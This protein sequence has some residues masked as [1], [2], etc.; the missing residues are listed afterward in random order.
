ML[1]KSLKLHSPTANLAVRRTNLYPGLH[2]EQAL[3]LGLHQDQALTGLVLAVLAQQTTGL[4]PVLVMAGLVL[5]PAPAGL[6][7]EQD[8]AGQ[9]RLR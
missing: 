8:L 5:V 2:P 6:V 3:E 4:D 7:Q 1:P 9:T